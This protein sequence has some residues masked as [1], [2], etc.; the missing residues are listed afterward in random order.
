MCIRD[1]DYFGG[2]SDME[3]EQKIQGIE[4]AV[5]IGNKGLQYIDVGNYGL[6]KLLICVAAEQMLEV[7]KQVQ[8]DPMRQNQIKEG[9]KRLLDRA[10]FCKSMVDSQ[11]NEL[12]RDPIYQTVSQNMIDRSP[13]ILFNDI[14][15][16]QRDAGFAKSQTRYLLWNTITPQRHFALWTSW[17]WK[18]V[19]R[20]GDSDGV[21]SKIL[22]YECILAGVEILRRERKDSADVVQTCLHHAAFNH[23][24]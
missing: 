13:R 1:R 18:D 6:A 11:L 20:E 12:S 10:E 21:Q 9:I 14:A 4:A 15:N 7:S 24:H 8:S 5:D 23:F 19:Y 16:S 3:E 2:S 22:Q 17:K